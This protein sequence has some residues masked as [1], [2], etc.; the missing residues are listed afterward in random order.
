MTGRAA[1]LKSSDMVLT[2]QLDLT[3][4]WKPWKATRAMFHGGRLRALW[5][6]PLFVRIW[7]TIPVGSTAGPLMAG[8]HAFFFPRYSVPYDFLCLRLIRSFNP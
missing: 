4:F 5:I 2:M 7:H 8:G 6:R 1:G 3:S